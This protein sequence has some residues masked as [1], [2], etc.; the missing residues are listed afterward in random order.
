MKNIKDCSK[1]KG[2]IKLLTASEV[3]K[4]IR[5]GME[6]I[7]ILDKFNLKINSSEF[8]SV[9]GPSGCGKSTLLSILSGIDKDI[10]GK[11]FI[12]DIDIYS[13]TEKKLAQFRNEN[14]GIVFQ[15]SNLIQSLSVKE[16]VEIP[17][18]LAH[19]GKKSNMS[20]KKILSYM[21]MGN[22][23]NKKVGSLSGG[24]QQRVAIARALIQSP[25]IIFA[26]EPTG[27]LDYDNSMLVIDLFKQI[28]KEFNVTIVLATHDMNIA[29]IADR[30]INM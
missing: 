23:L 1:I 30:I 10:T 5:S 24:E 21:N 2:G 27:A 13:L 12:N 3:T 29:Q 6:L 4:T 25:K 11:I 26:D 18:Y 22:K 19:K 20:A 15:K 7:K 8:I 16:N 28:Q 9:C 17:Q 14:L